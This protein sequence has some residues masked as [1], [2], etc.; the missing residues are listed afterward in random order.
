MLGGKKWGI[1]RIML[2]G[3]YTHI[4]DSK[5]RLALPA[6]F[7]KEI[8]DK[9]VITHGLDNCL[10]VYPMKKWSSVAEKLS[11]MSM[12][13][14]DSRGFNRFILAGAVESDVDQAGRILIPDFLKDFA[15]LKSKVI[16]AGIH[17]RVE[18][19]SEP[20]WKLYKSRMVGQASTLAEKLGDVGAI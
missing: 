20:I 11:L 3:E 7:R 15:K 13:K 10:T 9:V 12:G 8:G 1:F 4:L 19:W 14:S 17:D 2:I 18:I 5:K 6:K 16:V